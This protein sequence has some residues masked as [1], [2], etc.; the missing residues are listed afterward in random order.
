MIKFVDNVTKKDIFDDLRAGDT[1][2]FEDDLYMKV[3]PYNLESLRYN[4]VCLN[5]GK[6]YHFT[7]CY[8]EEVDLQVAI[9]KKVCVE[10]V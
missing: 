1:F 5:D 6:L 7:K 3:Q 4:A 8:V 2:M 10:D 9:N